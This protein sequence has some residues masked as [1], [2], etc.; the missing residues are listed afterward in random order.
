[1][2]CCLIR[3]TEASGA[4]NDDD[5]GVDPAPGVSDGHAFPAFHLEIDGAEGVSKRPDETPPFGTCHEGVPSGDG[6][7]GASAGRVGCL[8]AARYRRWRRCEGRV[9]RQYGRAFGVE[10]SLAV[11]AGTGGGVSPSVCDGFGDRTARDA[12]D[13]RG[14]SLGARRLAGSGG[15]DRYGG[16]GG[17]RDTC[18]V[19]DVWRRSV[20][21]GQAC[22]A[23]VCPAHLRCTASCTV[24]I[25]PPMTEIRSSGADWRMFAFPRKV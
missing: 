6:W 3:V 13:L 16:E 18:P 8:P 2:F 9:L 22:A 19:R 24:C 17:D 10:G 5:T 7:S 15:H 12:V 21:F 1:M 4:G 14:S 23:V 11:G 20:I 25:V